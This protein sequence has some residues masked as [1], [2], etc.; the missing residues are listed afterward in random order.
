MDAKEL[1]WTVRNLFN[2]RKGRASHKIIRKRIVEGT[3]ID[4]IHLFQLITAMVIA[5]IGLNTDSTEAVV[6][7][8]L[9]CPLM[10]SVLAI[11]YAV[12]STDTK[13]LREVL[14]GL[15]VQIGVCLV[16]STFYFALSPLSNKTSE[17]LTNSNATVWD[18]LIAFLGGFAGALGSSRKQT[19]STLVA[20]VAVATALMPPLCSTGY[21][22]AM[23][24]LPLAVSAFY[25]FLIN[26]VFI[27]FGSEL[28]FVWLKTPLLEDLD[29]DGVVTAAEEAEAITRSARMRKQLIIASLVFAIPCLFFSHRVIKSTMEQNGT[30][31]E[32]RDTYD[33][34]YTTL[35]L[36]VVCPGL[37]S[38]RIGT[39]DSYNED[40]DQLEQRVVATVETSGELSQEDQE[41]VES[42]IRLNVGEVDDVTF[43]VA[44]K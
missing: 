1:R 39:E 17:L 4:G 13:M 10:G 15:L 38:Y 43:E 32:V 27:A 14:I 7:A 6:G 20:G 33:T 42:L 11:A 19:P 16:T 41:Q 29:G 28:V 23:R 35:E 12:A 3:E 24:D 37:Q 5:S 9:I 40:T 18:V 8:M 26:V 21:G 2:V 22:L 31:F 44:D 30:V 34:E 25:E 36:K